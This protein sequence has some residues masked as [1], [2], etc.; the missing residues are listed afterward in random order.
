MATE[1]ADIR[2]AIKTRLAANFTAIPVAEPG[3]DVKVDGQSYFAQWDVDF[4]PAQR[5]ALGATAGD[6]INGALKLSVLARKDATAQPG[7]ATLEGYLDTLRGIFPAGLS[8]AAGSKTL[9]FRVPSP[10]PTINIEGW[11]GREL[12]CPFYL[13]TA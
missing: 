6:R 3:V 10:G 2:A 4:L 5:A 7:T 8:V 9:N 13:F 12:S 1:L 11:V